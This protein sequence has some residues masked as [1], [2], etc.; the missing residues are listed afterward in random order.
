MQ[1]GCLEKEPLVRPGIPSI[2][3]L[4]KSLLRVLFR[5]F[6]EEGKL[7]YVTESKNDPAFCSLET[8]R[9]KLDRPQT[10]LHPQMSFFNPI[11]FLIEIS[12]SYFK[13]IK[14]FLKV[15]MPSF[16]FPVSQKHWQPWA[17][18]LHCDVSCG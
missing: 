10:M 15:Q 7:E 3:V 8:R 4:S 11:I 9:C 17:A 16:G 6:G 5:R 14:F 18:F 2:V 13:I 1:L 12:I